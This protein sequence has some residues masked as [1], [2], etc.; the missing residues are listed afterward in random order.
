MSRRSRKSTGGCPFLGRCCHFPF[1]RP[2]P[3][4]L[5]VSAIHGP[6]RSTVGWM[7]NPLNQA[8][9][10][11]QNPSHTSSQPSWASFTASTPRVVRLQGNTTFFA[12]GRCQ[13]TTGRHEMRF[14]SSVADWTQTPALA[15]GTRR[16]PRHGPDDPFG[17]TETSPPRTYS[18]VMIASWLS[19]TS[20]PSP[21]AT[22]PVT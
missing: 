4:E 18:S 6:G 8:I 17:C 22:L 7:G 10:S 20:G 2:L 14:E 12:A 19:L 5:R 16:S 11:V 15:S 9:S 1:R 21:S 13:P 3:W